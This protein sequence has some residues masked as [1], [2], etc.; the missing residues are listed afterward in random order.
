VKTGIHAVNE[1]EAETNLEAGLRRHDDFA[2]PTGES[3]EPPLEE[4]GIES[5]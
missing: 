3:L 2:S 5:R 4:T 1:L